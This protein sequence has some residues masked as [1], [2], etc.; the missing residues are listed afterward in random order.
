MHDLPMAC[1]NEKIGKMIGSTIGQVLACDVNKD[2]RAW[3]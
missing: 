3:G 2:G 1:I